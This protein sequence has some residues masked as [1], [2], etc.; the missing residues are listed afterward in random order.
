LSHFARRYSGSR[1]FFPF[2]RLLRCFSSPAYLPYPMCS[3][4]DDWALP[5]PGFPIRKSAGQ[6]L[7]SASPRLIAAVHVLLRLLVPRHPPCALII[8]TEELFRSFHYADFKVRTEQCSA[9]KNRTLMRGLS[10]LNSVRRRSHGVASSLPCRHTSRC[11]KV[12]APERWT[13]AHH[14]DASSTSGSR[15][16]DHRIS[17]ERR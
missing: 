16:G 15:G 17:L 14:V 9:A 2:L 6:R 3:D 4:T 5:Q 1:G 11:P 8:L 12:S 7:F 10:K 13:E